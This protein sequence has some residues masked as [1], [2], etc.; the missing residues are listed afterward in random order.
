MKYLMD[1][2]WVRMRGESSGQKGRPMRIYE[3]AIPITELM[4]SIEKGKP[5]PRTLSLSSGSCGIVSDNIPG[6]PD[7]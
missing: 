7:L 1:K 5:K 2:G 4:N 3:L 6:N